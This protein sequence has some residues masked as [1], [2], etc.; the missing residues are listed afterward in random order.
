M[1]ICYY[2]ITY[3]GKQ[4]CYKSPVYGKKKVAQRLNIPQKFISF[5]VTDDLP[6]WPPLP[7]FT[8][9]ARS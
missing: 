1:N 4:Y 2:T 3:N 7:K 6:E 9:S 5:G 8:P